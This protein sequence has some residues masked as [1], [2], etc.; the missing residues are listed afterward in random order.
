MIDSNKLTVKAQ[1]AFQ[2]AQVKALR[3]SHQEVDGE[4]LLL[5]L[6][7]QEDG[8]TRV[9]LLGQTCGDRSK[10]LQLR[11]EADKP[12]HARHHYDDVGTHPPPCNP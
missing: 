10:S 4:H 2:A 8:L 3:Y 7:E 6:L 1:E 12:P 11:S 5:A 9:S